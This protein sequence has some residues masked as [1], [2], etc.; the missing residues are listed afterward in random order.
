MLL[1]GDAVILILAYADLVAVSLALINLPF[2]S[3]SGDLLFFFSHL[4]SLVVAGVSYM[5]GVSRF[6]VE[7]MEQADSQNLGFP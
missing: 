4:G 1:R 3:Y 6:A 2:L 5:L 7:S